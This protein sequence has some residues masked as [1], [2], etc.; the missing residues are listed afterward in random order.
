M[1]TAS[2]AFGD[3]SAGFG[4]IGPVSWSG[5]ATAS[6]RVRDA[7]GFGAFGDDSA[8]FGSTG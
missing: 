2:G 1:P 4:S 6:A 3:D 7:Y 8:G 5:R